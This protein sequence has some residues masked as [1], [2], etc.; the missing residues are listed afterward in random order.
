MKSRR[1]GY[2]TS[3][4]NVLG[5]KRLL[6]GMHYPVC[7]DDSDKENDPNHAKDE[8]RV[9]VYCR[10]KAATTVDVIEA[11]KRKSSW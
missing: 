4:N 2:I 8:R 1:N 5:P 7:N 3:N 10:S 9:C 11:K 6:P